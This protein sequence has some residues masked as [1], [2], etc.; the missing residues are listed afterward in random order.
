MH[1]YTNDIKRFQVHLA[2]REDARV[3]N[4]LLDTWKTEPDVH[5][6]DQSSEL[7]IYAM[8]LPEDKDL[9]V[10]AFDAQISAIKRHMI[11]NL[12]DTSVFEAETFKEARRIARGIVAA[13]RKRAVDAM[14]EKEKGAYDARYAQKMPFTEEMIE[15]HRETY[16]KNESSTIEDKRAYLATT[17]GYHLGNRPSEQTSNGPRPMDKNGNEDADHRY[18][19][20]D[21]QYQIEDGSS[22]GSD[23]NETNIHGNTIYSHKGEVAQGRNA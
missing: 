10:S 17:V 11:N 23:I 16:W 8:K 1:N 19:V 7:A 3:Q 9:C 13:S 18:I 15:K 6:Y 14:G 5:V 2:G 12:R 22:I 20:E 4:Y 21:I